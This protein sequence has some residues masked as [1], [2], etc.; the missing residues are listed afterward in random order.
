MEADTPQHGIFNW[1]QNSRPGCNLSLTSRTNLMRLDDLEEYS[2][3]FVLAILICLIGAGAIIAQPGN[4]GN[5]E[6]DEQKK[7]EKV[8]LAREDADGNIE[9]DV[10]TFLPTDVPIICYVDLVSSK[11]STVS[12]KLIAV[13]VEGLFPNTALI[14]ISYKTKKREDVV[15]FR[16]RPEKRWLTGSYRVEILVNGKPAAKKGFKVEEPETGD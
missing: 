13:D 9:K 14:S 6:P 15:T 10:E 3:R 7:V 4:S 11:P 12:L 8:T 5:K 16:G 2:M 1:S